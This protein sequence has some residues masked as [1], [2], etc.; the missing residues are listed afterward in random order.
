MMKSG[1][2]LLTIQRT[3]NG[4]YEEVILD[5]DL[6]NDYEL[7]SKVLDHE[8]SKQKEKSVPGS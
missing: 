7:N 8:P 5:C 6:K 4:L 2:S 1:R 3:R